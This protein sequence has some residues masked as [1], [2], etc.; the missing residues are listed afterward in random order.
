MIHVCAE[1]IFYFSSVLKKKTQFG[2]TLV[3]F[4]LRKRGSNRFGYYSCFHF[5]TAYDVTLTSMTSL[6]T[7]TTSK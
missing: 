4:G 7:M 3:Q 2:M 1:Y 5:A 6:K